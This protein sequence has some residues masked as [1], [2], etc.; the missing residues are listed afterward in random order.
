[1]GMEWI[2]WL[3][4]WKTSWL[5]KYRWLNYIYSRNQCP[6]LQVKRVVAT[7]LSSINSVS[8][9]DLMVYRRRVL[10]SRNIKYDLFASGCRLCILLNALT[11]LENQWIAQ[12]RGQ[13]LPLQDRT[14]NEE[15][16][17]RIAWCCFTGQIRLF[18]LYFSILVDVA[19][20]YT[21]DLHIL[22]SNDMMMIDT[23]SWY[24]LLSP[25]G[26]SSKSWNSIPEIHQI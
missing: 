19:Y 26:I 12:P 3:H 4:P 16:P 9:F 21:H 24:R 20:Y 17:K 5:T 7:V 10:R 8:K 25:C 6:C 1:M 14:G 15:Q 18:S 13:L 2:D 11:F 22:P 23:S